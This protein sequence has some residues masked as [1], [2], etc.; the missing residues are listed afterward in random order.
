[1]S[2]HCD[3]RGEDAGSARHQDGAPGPGAQESQAGEEGDC[4]GPAGGD[5]DPQMQVRSPESHWAL[6]REITQQI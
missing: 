3:A 2:G 4:A 6:I 5:S 1:M